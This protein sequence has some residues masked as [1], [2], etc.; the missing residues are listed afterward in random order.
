MATIKKSFIFQHTIVQ[1]CLID[2]VATN[3][4]SFP[5]MI[6]NPI[7]SFFTAAP[8]PRNASV[9]QSPMA[10]DCHGNHKFPVHFITR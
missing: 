4:N 2:G 1:I 3:K 6:I 8:L 9:C 5:F 10:A 7:T